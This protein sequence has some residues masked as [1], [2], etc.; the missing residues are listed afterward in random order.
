MSVLLER[1]IKD[2]SSNDGG[3]I[4]HYGGKFKNNPF[5][6][7][8]GK[9]KKHEDYKSNGMSMIE[10][11]SIIREFDCGPLALLLYR[12]PCLTF[13]GGLKPLW[14]IWIERVGG[15]VK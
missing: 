8:E 1:K 9:I 5:R 15:G 7:D 6:Y 2:K 10:M 4:I 3:K 11:I 13:V 14:F 12:D